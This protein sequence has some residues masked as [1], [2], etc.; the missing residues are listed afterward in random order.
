M[1]QVALLNTVFKTV[2]YWCKDR[3]YLKEQN[4]QSRNRAFPRRKWHIALAVWITEEGT[5]SCERHSG[6]WL[7]RQRKTKQILI[8]TQ[9]S[10]PCRLRTS[11][12]NAKLLQLLGN[13]KGEY[14]YDLCVGTDFLKKKQK[15]QNTNKKTY[16]F[17]YIKIKISK[18]I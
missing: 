16:N 7:T 14:I 4:T 15:A 8:C 1:K 5:N 12:R 10:I 3:L 13:C 17:D 11:M 18:D 2:W 6:S 9:Q